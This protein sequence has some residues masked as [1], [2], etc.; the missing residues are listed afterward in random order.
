MGKIRTFPQ[1]FFI[2]FLLLVLCIRD[3]TGTFF[4]GANSFSWLFSGVKCFFLV[5]NFHFARPKTNFGGFEKWEA[6][7]KNQNKTKGSLLILLL[8]HLPFPIFHLPF[9]IFLLFFSVFF[10][11]FPCLFF[12]VGQQKF[13]GQ[14]SLGG[15]LP[16]PPTSYA[17]ALCPSTSTGPGYIVFH[18]CLSPCYSAHY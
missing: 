1:F 15:T 17:A 14:K 2:L 9:T 5:E 8:F 3:A 12:P 7:K 18:G 6:K 4:W 13:P 11:F 16:L 10:P